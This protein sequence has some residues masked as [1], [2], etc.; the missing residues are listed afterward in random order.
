MTPHPKEFDRLEG[1]TCNGS[2]DRL[3]KAL[4]MA[5]RMHCYIILK[6]HFSALCTPKHE[7][8]F[9]STGNSGM[10]TAG[11]GDVL[12]GIITAQVKT[13]AFLVCICMV[14]LATLL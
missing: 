8:I 4:N 7:V 2:Y 12:T 3:N 1:A 14:W 6:D 13:P 5:E 11:S 10:A 9:N